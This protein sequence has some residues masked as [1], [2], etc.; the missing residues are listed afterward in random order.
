MLRRTLR[1][2][3]SFLAVA[4]A[5][6]AVLLLLTGG[7]ET[8]VAGVAISAHDPLRPLLAAAL[9]LTVFI[10][11]G[12]DLRPLFGVLGAVAARVA[13][14]RRLLA[15]PSRVA[16]AFAI[17]TTLVAWVY[18]TK[19][20]GGADSYG[21]LSQSDLW[22]EGSLKVHQ[23]FAAQVPWPT[24]DWTFAPIGSYRPVS[25]F[26]RVQGED[27]W[28][29]VPV[30][31]PGLPILLAA[32]GAVGG[33]QAKFSL[34]ALLAGLLVIATYG[35]GVRLASPTAALIGAFLVATSPAVIFMMVSPMSDVAV[36]GV[37]AA[38][39]FLVLGRGPWSAAGA[40]L[41]ASLAVLIRPNLAPLLGVM[42]LVY[43]FRLTE[44]AAR[45]AA[46]R[47]AALFAVSAVPAVATLAIVNQTLYGSAVGSG[48]GHVGGLFSASYIPENV[49]NYLWWLVE[50]HTVV[51]AVGLAAA[52]TPS[53]WLWNAAALKSRSTL[54]VGA[55]CIAAV[56]GTYFV[57]KPWDAWWYLR[58]LLP[59][60]PLIM[61]GTGAVLAKLVSVRPAV[62]GPAV[63]I[64]VA[65]LGVFQVRVAA[66]RSAFDLWA[67]ERRYVQA[68]RM[69]NA[70]TDR[71]SLIIT[72]VHAGSVR[73]YGSR[74]SA[75]YEHLPS[76]WLDRA[77]RWLARRGV[78]SYLLLEEWEV[79]RA[80]A[81]FAGQETL[82]VL[83]WP[84]AAI[85]QHPGT[86]YLFD[87]LQTE[88]SADRPVMWT[89][90]DRSLWATPRAPAPRFAFEEP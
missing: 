32:A 81:H 58:F 2:W 57:Y 6:W 77:V 86:M 66:D 62:I 13:P 4:G 46:L 49:Y 39:F 45:R 8:T 40:G 71:N 63:G 47:D 33:I 23:P 59:T 48:Y 14:V 5:A 41:L 42:G 44:R 53:R 20:V 70:V 34:F 43:L 26:R 18:G 36:S 10:L 30:Y 68:A 64:A 90:T 67:G 55:L 25:A 76:E 74:M 69:A 38:S 79:P 35:I 24:A 31:P 29:I 9:S 27:R 80:R 82:R 54:V 52:L 16:W 78:R 19:A 11:A 88:P 73:Y 15:R 12:G 60:F 28:F 72:G 50:T 37:W 85:Y 17:A 83:D 1:R 21:Y 75:Y 56:W 61:L 89:G 3:T 65:M 84:A 51:A 87:L 7:F 22:A